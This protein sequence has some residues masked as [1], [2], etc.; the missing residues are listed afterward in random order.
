M[1][2]QTPAAVFN[3]GQGDSIADL[4]NPGQKVNYVELGQELKLAASRLR[5][6][7]RGGSAS[8]AQQDS[9]AFVSSAPEEKDLQASI[10]LENQGDEILLRYLRGEEDPLTRDD[11]A[12]CE[13]LF[14]QTLTLQPLSPYL[15]A[16]EEFCEG[17]KLVFDKSYAQAIEHLENS[18]RLDP[19]E[20]YGFNALGIAYL[21]QARYDLATAAFQDAIDRAP[22]WAYPLHNLALTRTQTGDYDNAI[23]A[24]K[25][26]MLLAQQYSY[27]PYNLGLVFQKI[28]RIAEAQRAYEKAASLTTTK[29]APEIA[30]GLL[31]ANTGREADALAHYDSALERLKQFPD[32]LNLAVASHNKAA[33]LARH[34]D[35]RDAAISLWRDNI[36]RAAYLP[37]RVSLAALLSGIAGQR[38]QDW[39][40]VANEAVSQY[41]AILKEEPDYLSAQLNSADLLIALGRASEALPDM[42]LIAGKHPAEA[43]VQEKLGDLQ[44]ASGMP[45]EAR[46]SWRKALDQT[47]SKDLRLRVGQKLRAAR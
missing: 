46:A 42:Q 28:N 11:F 29:A 5:S 7:K 24:Y 20:A 21:E 12:R 47:K 44:L 43:V 38:R 40:V 2:K 8:A 39:R 30:L 32:V 26:A 31:M 4:S 19:G 15:M 23:A 34:R 9:S 45:E 1:L 16:R 41:Q 36:N 6:V 13:D 18:I 17:R 37:S 10:D 3:M 33:L 22:L 25:K 27:L 35:T 14:R